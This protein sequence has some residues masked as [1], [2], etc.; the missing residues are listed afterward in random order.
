MHRFNVTRNGLS[1]CLAS[2]APGISAPHERHP[3]FFSSRRRHTRSKRDWSSDVCSSD[4]FSA[5]VSAGTPLVIPFFSGERG[6][7]WRGSS[8]AVFANVG[9]STTWQD[10]LRGAMEGIALS[11]LRIADQLREAGGEPARIVLSGGLPG[12]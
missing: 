11:F 8:R 4:L 6:T 12:A 1:S 9:A 2:S 3:F 7:K 10:M 5:P